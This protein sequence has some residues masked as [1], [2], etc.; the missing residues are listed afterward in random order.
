MYLYKINSKMN[1]S[2]TM[3]NF[4]ATYQ[5]DKTRSGFTYRY[6]YDIKTKTFSNNIGDGTNVSEVEIE[7]LL[8]HLKKYDLIW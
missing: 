1:D 3:I 5:P 2:G 8:P 4:N 7:S 6:T